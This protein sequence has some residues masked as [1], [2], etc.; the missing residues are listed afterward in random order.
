MS[1]L[2]FGVEMEIFIK[3]TEIIQKLI[4]NEIIV[5]KCKN[6]QELIDFIMTQTTYK[7]NT[8][9]SD[10]YT[11]YY[12]IMMI[13]LYIICKKNI[14]GRSGSSKRL[15]RPLFSLFN[16]PYAADKN[17]QGDNEIIYF[18]D[19]K[20]TSN[21]HYDIDVSLGP[22]N[23][24]TYRTIYDNFPK[25][26]SNKELIPYTEFVSPI[27]DNPEEV[28]EGVGYLISSLTDLKLTPLHSLKTSNHIHF[29][30][31]KETE[32]DKG[33][34]NPYLVFCIT[35]VFYVLQNF[36]YL[37]CLPERRTSQ[38][39][40]PL[41]IEKHLWSKRFDDFTLDEFFNVPITMKIPTGDEKCYLNHSEIERLSMIF[42]EKSNNT[43]LSNKEIL[44]KT[45]KLSEKIYKLMTPITD[46]INKPFRN[47]TFEH[48]LIVLMH[49]YH[50]RT[51]YKMN[52]LFNKYTID[53]VGGTNEVNRYKILNLKKLS[54]KESCTLELRVKHGSNDSTEI[55]NFCILIEKLVNLAEQMVTNKDMPL[56]KSL[57]SILNIDE[58][59]LFYF[60]ELEPK[61][62]EKHYNHLHYTNVKPLL[63]KILKSLFKE[64]NISIK[65]W[66][67]Q[68][69]RINELKDPKDPK[70]PKAVKSLK[71]LSSTKS[72][73]SARKNTL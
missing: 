49:F 54:E 41:E 34:K 65:Y 4:D 47:L 17:Y 48:Q 44:K 26:L 39:C 30:I 21:W 2:T 59:E 29:S 50:K 3:R 53:I 70:D 55:A 42:L 27:F 71:S 23:E 13:I 56:L 11:I 6:L 63:K 51:T 9:L 7:P 10:D 15:G 25:I 37:I 64:D 57:A 18:K 35:Y 5:N 12:N 28:K 14:S 31:K 45:E 67:K 43:T 46:I 8:K 36:I 62:L 52:N 33:I 72:S 58:K 66:M 61:D 24:K 22:L 73:S 32:N 20:H 69:K 68:L 40:S 60:K 16:Y 19:F 1:K 38:Y